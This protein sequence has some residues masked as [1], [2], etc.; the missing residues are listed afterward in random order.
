MTGSSLQFLIQ[1]TNTIENLS[2]H[3][4]VWLLAVHIARPPSSPSMIGF[5]T[6]SY[7][8]TG[9]TPAQQPTSSPKTFAILRSKPGE[10]PW[11]LGPLENV[12]SVMGQHVFDWILPLKYSPCCNHDRAD[13]QFALGPAVERMRIEAGLMTPREA[14]SLP[15]MAERR[16]QRRSRRDGGSQRRRRSRSKEGERG[17]WRAEG[18]VEQ[19]SN[20]GVEDDSGI[21]LGEDRNSMA[22]W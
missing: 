2:R 10:N 11:D 14:V 16:R 22:R 5:S 7:P 8:L 4:K 20:L 15:T 6:I 3:S 13:S 1:N 12:K 18:E 9:A 21:A 19:S 17:R